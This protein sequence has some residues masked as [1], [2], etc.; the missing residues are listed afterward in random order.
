MS[1]TCAQ[2]GYDCGAAADGCGN[3]IQ[4]GNCSGNQT[5]GGGGSANVCGGGV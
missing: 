5:C 2:L 4:C 3:I 1:K